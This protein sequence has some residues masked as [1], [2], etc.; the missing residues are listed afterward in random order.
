MK[1]EKKD[2]LKHTKKKRKVKRCIYI[3]ARKRKMKLRRK[4]NQYVN[5]SRKFFG[6][7]QGK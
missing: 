7:K 4:M 3:K 2:V 6:R 5:R 1:M